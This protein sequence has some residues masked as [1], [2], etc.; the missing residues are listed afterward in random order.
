MINEEMNL[1]M[2]Y[3]PTKEIIIVMRCDNEYDV[4]M[5]ICTTT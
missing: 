4:N 5:Y 1:A 3:H 2:S